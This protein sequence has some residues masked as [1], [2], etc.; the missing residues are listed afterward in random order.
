[1]PAWPNSC[2][3]IE[4]KPARTNSA[5]S[6]MPCAESTLRR[7]NKP[8]S[9]MV[10]QKNGSTLTGMR[11]RWKRIMLP[12]VR[13]GRPPTQEWSAKNR[14]GGPAGPLR[15]G[16]VSHRSAAWRREMRLRPAAAGI[17]IG[18]R[19][20]SE[21]FHRRCRAAARAGGRI[22][23]QPAGPGPLPHRHG[24]GAWHRAAD[25]PASQRPLRPP[26]PINS[27][28]RPRCCGTGWHCHG[29]A[30]GSVPAPAVPGCA[31]Q[32]RGRWRGRPPRPYGSERHCGRP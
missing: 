29:P 3:K 20:A 18:P 4:T 25:L 1:M 6:R 11:N 27:E 9:P 22:G 24:P 5:S 8:I 30:G 15:A 23:S 26:P 21:N 28:E 12:V 19:D 17:R 14:P 7:D 13:P 16:L 32:R 31:P 2:T 10:I